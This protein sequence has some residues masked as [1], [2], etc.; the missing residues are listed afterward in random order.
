MRDNTSKLQSS[1]SLR[2]TTKWSVFC[3][4]SNWRK[5]RAYDREDNPMVHIIV[6]KF[7]DTA[8]NASAV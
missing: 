4:Q 7:H 3:S 2:L 8:L 6:I 5:I 1:R